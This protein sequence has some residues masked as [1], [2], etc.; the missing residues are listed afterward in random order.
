VSLD[1]LI[2]DSEPEP[3][4]HA[5]VFRRE[6]R[7]EELVEMFRSNAASIIVRHLVA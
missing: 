5:R 1:D 7:L 6:S 3:G 4:A 2:A